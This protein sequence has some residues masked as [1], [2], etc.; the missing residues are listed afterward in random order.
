MQF[1][2]RYKKT[3]SLLSELSCI[4]NKRKVYEIQKYPPGAEITF[5]LTAFLIC[6]QINRK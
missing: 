5:N 1:Y 3:D 4:Y 6:S 2:F